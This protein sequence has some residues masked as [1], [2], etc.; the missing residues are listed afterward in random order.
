MGVEPTAVSISSAD[1]ARTLLASM[2]WSVLGTGRTIAVGAAALSADER[3]HWERRLN[4]W[5]S[6]C[7]C[8]IGALVAVLAAVRCAVVF[9]DTAAPLLRVILDDLAFVLCAAVIGKITALIIARSIFTHHIG[10]LVRRLAVSGA[11]AA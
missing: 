6:A 11:K 2:R 8:T 1:D 7:G 10:Y 9:R 4:F 5:G 3:Q